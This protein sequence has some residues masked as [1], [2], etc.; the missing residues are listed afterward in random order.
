MTVADVEAALAWVDAH[1]HLLAPP[2][3]DPRPDRR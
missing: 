1:Q 3:M 2:L